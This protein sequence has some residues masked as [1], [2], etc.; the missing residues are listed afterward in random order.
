MCGLK[1]DADAIQDFLSRQ[2]GE[3]WLKRSERRVWPQFVFHYTDITNTVEILR[4][5]CLYSRQYLEDRDR[6]PVSAGSPSV[7]AGTSAEYKDCVRLYFRPRT[8]T[9]F[10]AEGIHSRHSLARS[11][12]PKAHCPVPVFFLFDA[13]TVLARSDCQFS[14]GG[15]N[16]PRACVFSTATDLRNL[17]WKRIYHTGRYDPSQ[18]EESDI[19]FRRNAEVIVPRRL[20]LS[21]LRY[22][23]CRSAAERET[24]LHL[25]D[26]DL[27]DRYARYIVASTRS[28]LFYRQ[29]TFIETARLK[30]DGARFQFSPETKSP[31]PFKLHIDIMAGANECSY[32]DENFELRPPHIFALSYRRCLTNYA[33]RLR[34]DDHVAYCN[35]YQETTIPF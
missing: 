21:A 33:I 12:Y 30:S 5:D 20:D 25:L 1:P 13:A 23:Y 4:E 31:G 10:Y 9:Q 26:Y 17:P 28:D 19:A 24:L 6:L 3:D 35:K 34:L 7:L 16:N 14:D 29:R 22:I 32:D 18:V 27:R 11:N 15:L 2:L 8:P